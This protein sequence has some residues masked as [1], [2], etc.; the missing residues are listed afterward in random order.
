MQ[1]FFNY[2]LVKLTS[3]KSMIFGGQLSIL[4]DFAIFP[5]FLRAELEKS[6]YSWRSASAGC[7]AA[8]SEA[9]SSTATMLSA[10]SEGAAGK[11]SVAT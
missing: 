4:A 6:G 8:L 2:L 1:I 7:S 5:V 3:K 10:S 9:G 11:V